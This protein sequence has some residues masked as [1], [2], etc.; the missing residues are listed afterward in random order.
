MSKT[1]FGIIAE[2]GPLEAQATLLCES[3]RQF[4]GSYSSSR[5]VVISPRSD[6]RPTQRT[7][8]SLE[9]LR[10]EILF[11]DIESAVPEYGS[12]FRI[13]AAATLE[14]NCSEE[15]LVF[16]DSDIFF[17]G[18][19]SLGLGDAHA[20]ARPVDLKGMCTTGVEDTNDAYWQNLCKIC[21]VEYESLPYI[22]TTVDK[23][24][25]KASYNGGFVVVRPAAS[26]FQR[27]EEFFVKSVKS[28]LRPYADRG[29][30]IQAG[31]GLVA[32]VG[33]EYWGSS[34]ACLSLAIWGAASNA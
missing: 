12:S 14:A 21:S 22:T 26:I 27:T 4:G 1:V 25:V 24:P 13:H 15:Q 16:L 34:Q 7:I 30:Q 6:R 8:R 20:A 33:A 2:E 11:L 10:A 9:A 5:L 19:P 28:N 31:H 3:V 32:G 29:L 17:C 23:L 18:E